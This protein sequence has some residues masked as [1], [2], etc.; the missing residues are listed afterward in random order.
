MGFLTSGYQFTGTTFAVTTSAMHAYQ[1]RKFASDSVV[2]L[3]DGVRV[4]SRAYSTLPNTAVGA[5][6]AF[7]FGGPGAVVPG[8]KNVADQ[9]TAW[10]HVIYEIGVPTP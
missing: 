4:G 8:P 3:V 6:S 5:S 9:S 2:L 10:D 7:F 1:I